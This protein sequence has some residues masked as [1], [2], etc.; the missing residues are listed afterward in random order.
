[1]RVYN[2]RGLLA[3]LRL[4]R[5]VLR[6]IAA[7]HSCYKAD[8]AKE[9]RKWLLFRYVDGELTPLSKPFTTKALAEKARKKYSERERKAIA[10]GLMRTR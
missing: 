9:T 5:Q 6:A 10:I 3:L 8:M 1:M 7:C 4:R 2:P